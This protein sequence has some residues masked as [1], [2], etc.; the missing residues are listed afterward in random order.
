MKTRR[1]EGRQKR[2]G[3]RGREGNSGEKVD[4]GVGMWY[5]IGTSKE[6]FC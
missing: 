1:R 6:L 4:K 2:E 5:V 3:R